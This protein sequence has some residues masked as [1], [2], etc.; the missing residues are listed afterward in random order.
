MRQN[1]EGIGLRELV[2]GLLFSLQADGRSARTVGY[3]RDLLRLLLEYAQQRGWADSP[4]AL[5]VHRVR[6][7]LSWTG[8]RICEHTVGNGTKRIRKAKSTTAWPYYRAL[9]RLFNWA[10][11][12][13]YLESSP[14][15]T[16]HFRPPPAPPVEGYTVSELKGCSQSVTL[17]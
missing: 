6:E 8:S 16:I 12:E 1:G 3:Y 13:G 7:F 17:T 4:T 10:V 14:L 9:R 2:D 11:E 5:D 15:A